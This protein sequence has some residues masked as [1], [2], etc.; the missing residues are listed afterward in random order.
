MS[1]RPSL[2]ILTRARTS[3]SRKY[4][5][6]FVIAVASV[7]PISALNPETIKRRIASL[8]NQLIASLVVSSFVV[9]AAIILFFA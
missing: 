4:L 1:T 3:S 2:S 8:R 5:T 9:L 6:T 7:L